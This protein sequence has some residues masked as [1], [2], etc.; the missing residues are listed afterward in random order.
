MQVGK[1]NNSEALF[2]TLFTDVFRSQPQR[3]AASVLLAVVLPLC[4][5][6]SILLLIPILNSADIAVGPSAANSVGELFHSVLG[7]LGVSQSLVSA[8]VVFVT[9]S[10]IHAMLLWYQVIL[11]ARLRIGFVVSRQ[12]R[13]SE[14]ISRAHWSFFLQV[15]QQDLA[16]TLSAYASVIHLQHACDAAAECSQNE[17]PGRKMPLKQAIELANVGFRYR[18]ESDVWAM[19]HVN[20][21]FTAGSVTAIVGQSGSGKSTLADLLLGLL[22]PEEGQISVDGACIHDQLSAWRGVIGYVPQETFLLHDTIRANLLWGNPAASEDEIQDVMRLASIADVVTAL[23]DGLET[24]VGERGTRL[25]GGERQRIALARA[26]LRK[27][28]LLILDEATSTLDPAN[29]TCIQ[30]SLERLSG[31]L[32]IVVIAHQ[33]SAIINARQV[34]VLDRGRVVQQGDFD[35]LASKEGDFRK[36]MRVDQSDAV[37]R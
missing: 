34:I 19:R 10:A 7:T 27:P 5:G 23:P 17:L 30:K 37:L 2:R 21:T 9:V 4:S 35:E 26:L 3:C 32:T 18:T 28:S 14:A 11:N 13:L 29:Q 12:N 16:H 1:H 36:L 24:V 25:S 20:L 33:Q 8:L 15:R 31:R 6:L 22:S